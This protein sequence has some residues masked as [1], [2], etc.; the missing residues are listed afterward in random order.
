MAQEKTPGEMLMCLKVCTIFSPA[1]SDISRPLTYV[2]LLSFSFPHKFM[3][4]MV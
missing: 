2:P 1:M 4:G 3:E